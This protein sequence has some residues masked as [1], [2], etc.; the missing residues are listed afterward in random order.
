MTDIND[1]NVSVSEGQQISTSITESNNI[2]VDI[3]GSI[4]G[5]TVNWGGIQGTLSDQ[6]DL[7]A[8]LDAKLESGDNVS[9]LVNDA[10]Y[11]TSAPFPDMLPACFSDAT[12]GQTLETTPTVLNLDTTDI[13]NANYSLAS[14]TIT[15]TAANT[16]EINFVIT[17]DFN[18]SAATTQR[19]AW[20]I[21]CQVEPSGGGGYTK[22]SLSEVSDYWREAGGNHS[23]NSTFF[24]EASA[25]DKLQ[26]VFVGQTGTMNSAFSTVAGR[27]NACIKRIG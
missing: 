14:D 19:D 26:F 27:N 13:S 22:I 9:E 1:I 8:A 10:G 25:G 5:S 20:D 3:Q 23:I 6:T 18:S 2:S 4:V 24:Y 11:L 16:Y 7:Q 17:C 12:G 21:Y 15:I